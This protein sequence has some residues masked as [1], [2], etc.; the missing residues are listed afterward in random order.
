L[1]LPSVDDGAVVSASL[2]NVLKLADFVNL[3]AG[4]RLADFLDNLFEPWPEAY[5]LPPLFEA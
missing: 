4:D 1:L 2:L 5:P 3:G